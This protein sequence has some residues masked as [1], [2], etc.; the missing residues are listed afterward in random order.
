[1]NQEIKELIESLPED[2]QEAMLKLR[3]SI[4]NN[5]PEGFEEKVSNNFIN[6]VVPYSIYPESY[7]CEPKQPLPFLSIASQRNHIAVYHMGIYANDELL[8][9]FTQEY[10]KHSKNKLDM[11]KSCIRFK[12]PKKIPFELLSELCTKMTPQDWVTLYEKYRKD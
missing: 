3:E 5:L 4:V 11:G 9:W 6:Y 10:P 7:H 2:R 8:K 1:M 12:N